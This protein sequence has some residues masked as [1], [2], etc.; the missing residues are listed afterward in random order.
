MGLQSVRLQPFTPACS[1]L[2]F[3]V[4]LCSI[5][6]T[7]AGAAPLNLVCNGNSYKADGPFPTPEA[8]L[9]AIGGGKSVLIG[10]P[11]NAQ[12]T[13][14]SIV[15]NNPFQLKFRTSKFTGEYFTFHRRF[16]PAPRRR[17]PHQAHLPA[18]LKTSMHLPELERDAR[19]R[20]GAG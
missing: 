19:Q 6:N 18:I 9:L 15:A 3:A 11:G 16:V 17:A 14:A 1:L 10:G 8:Y 12:P 13:K 2:A 4:L 7:M 5:N 20:F